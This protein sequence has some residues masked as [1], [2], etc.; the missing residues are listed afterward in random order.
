M[1]VPKVT[2]TDYLNAFTDGDESNQPQT[3]HQ[4]HAVVR[5]MAWTRTTRTRIVCGTSHPH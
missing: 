3:R 1:S 5:S 4:R 2:T